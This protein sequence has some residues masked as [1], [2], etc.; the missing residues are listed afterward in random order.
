MQLENSHLQPTYNLEILSCNPHASEKNSI[1]QLKNLNYNSRVTWK[2]FSVATHAQL[3]NIQLQP[4][5]NL[6]I[7]LQATCNPLVTKKY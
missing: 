5:C 7:L 6:K 4:T 1:A 3:K 2:L